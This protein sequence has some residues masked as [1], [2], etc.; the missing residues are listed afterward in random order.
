[1]SDES[2]HVMTV[3]NPLADAGLRCPRCD[4]N[5]TG[6]PEA[7]CPECGE[8]FDWE[9]VRRAADNPPRIYFERVR[10]WR[11]VPGFFVTWATVL[12]APWIFAR[13]AV[14]RVSTF[15][16]LL[17]VLTCFGG[18]FVAMISDAE[19]DFMATWLTTAAIYI[20]LQTVLLGVLDFSGWRQ[21][22]RSLRFW[23]LVSCYTSAIML[24]E[25]AYGG[26]PAIAFT[27]LGFLLAGE[28]PTAWFPSM[29]EISCLSVLGWVRL[30]VWLSGLA[31][32]YAVRVRRR[33]YALG[34]VIVATVLVTV[35]V[36]VLYAATFER[37]GSWV[38][39][40]FEHVY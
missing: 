40:G 18:T 8:A 1:M 34:L 22:L 15:H 12:F 29:Y 33:R 20:P 7:R 16:A 38:Y 19:L 30:A 26:P 24:T 37:I 3:A 28:K 35:L 2:T 25:V 21:P 31:C 39:D 13:Q 4:Y 10:G 23:L 14:A 5:L 9:A 36:V 6:L 32:C 17:F 11:K 27:D